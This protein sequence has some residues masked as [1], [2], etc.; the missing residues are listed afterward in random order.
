MLPIQEEHN[1]LTAANKQTPKQEV[2][3]DWFVTPDDSSANGSSSSD[4]ELEDE[5]DKNNSDKWYERND[6]ALTETRDM[7]KLFIGQARVGLDM[8]NSLQASA[9]SKKKVD[10]TGMRRERKSVLPQHIW[11]QVE[12]ELSKEGIQLVNRE[13]A[14]AAEGRTRATLTYYGTSAVF[15]NHQVRTKI[16]MRIRYYLSYVRQPD[17]TLTDV[18][19]EGA[20]KEKGFLELK[21]KSPRAFEENSVDKYRLL[22]FVRSIQFEI[23]FVP[24]VACCLSFRCFLVSTTRTLS[25]DF[26]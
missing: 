24:L 9:A 16:R 6:A 8:V 23:Q 19:R 4:D 5:G 12:Q 3:D 20:T 11:G 18:Q 26:I 17:G 21:V 13:K 2:I 14:G 22:S 7:R 1:L 25:P 10:V 15:F